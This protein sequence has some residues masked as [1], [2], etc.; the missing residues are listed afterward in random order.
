LYIFIL[1]VIKTSILFFYLR[2]FPD[3]IFRR[4]LWGTQVFNMLLGAAFL[5]AGLFQCTPMSYFWDGWDG[6]HLGYCFN[7]N[8]MGWAHAAVN[9]AL[10]VWMLALPATQIYDMNIPGHKKV[11]ILLMFGFG[12]LYG[13]ILRWTERQA[14]ANAAL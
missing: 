13:P 9:I 12:V 1:A 2:I 7:F 4:F 8:A 6:E 5:V 3:R 11:Q 14:W 10:D